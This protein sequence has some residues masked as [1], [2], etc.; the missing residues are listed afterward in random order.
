MKIQLLNKNKRELNF[1]THQQAHLSKFQSNVIGHSKTNCNHKMCN[2]D[3]KVIES[4][5]SERFSV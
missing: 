3:G 2:I 1:A 5:N 4:L